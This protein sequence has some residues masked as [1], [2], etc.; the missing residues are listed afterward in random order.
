MKLSLVGPYV[1]EM[2]RM[3]H[4]LHKELAD[5]IKNRVIDDYRE[6]TDYHPIL[7]IVLVF[8]D[9]PGVSSVEELFPMM[10]VFSLGGSKN[11]Y[12]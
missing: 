4:F 9:S 10:G 7:I 2:L 11:H 6:F 1:C 5:V 12:N 8:I 3:S